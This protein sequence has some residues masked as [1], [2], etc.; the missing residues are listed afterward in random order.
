MRIPL[1]TLKRRKVTGCSEFSD[2]AEQS[3][4]EMGLSEAGIAFVCLIWQD[5]TLQHDVSA[6]P[7][8][9]LYCSFLYSLIRQHSPA[10]CNQTVDSYANAT[11]ILLHE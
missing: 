1:R 8:P 2:D 3:R 11:F 7:I 4:W 9:L 6:A 10:S 5:W